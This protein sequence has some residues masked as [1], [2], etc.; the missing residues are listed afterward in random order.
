MKRSGMLMLVLGLG[1]A[2]GSS[3]ADDRPSDETMKRFLDESRRAATQLVQQVGGEMRKEVETGGP[4]RGIIVCKYNAPESAA[5]ISRKTGMRV[6]R[7]S[8][9]PRNPGLGFP[10][11]WEQRVLVDFDQRAARGEKPDTLEFFEVTTEPA[12]TFLRYMKAIPTGRI[13]LACHG[14]VDRLGEDVKAQ[15]AAEYPHDRATGY[16]EG[17]VRGAVTVKKQLK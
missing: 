1:S 15:L 4:L 16:S 8:L 7:V 3:I 11:Q 13:C 14:P 5:N 9:K 12:G 10:D 17:T 6:T 2:L